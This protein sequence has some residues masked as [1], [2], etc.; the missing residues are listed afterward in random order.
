MRIDGSAEPIY[1]AHDGNKRIGLEIT[2]AQVSLAGFVHLL[3][4][5]SF[6]MGPTTT[7]DIATGFP[8][9]IVNLIDLFADA[10]PDPIKDLVNDLSEKVGLGDLTDLSRL[11]NIEV[12][13]LTLA[14]TDVMGFVGINGPYWIDG[15]ENG[16]IDFDAD[17]KLL[18]S[19]PG[20]GFFPLWLRHDEADAGRFA[21]AW[22]TVAEILRIPGA[23]RPSSI[24]RHSRVCDG[25]RRHHDS[26][27][28]RDQ[29][30]R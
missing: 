27:K 3:G 22:R 1:L 11:E 29:V 2:N 30:A 4:N 10:I 9:D 20:L 15:N 26:C 25:S 13:T 14:A 5:F 18:E 24:C 28:Y 7:V 12:E 19:E 23:H 16:T 21:W 17:G 6:E 8:G